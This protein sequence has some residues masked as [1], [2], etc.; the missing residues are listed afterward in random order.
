MD[1]NGK[2]VTVRKAAY[3][4]LTLPTQPRKNDWYPVNLPFDAYLADVRNAED[5]LPPLLYLKDYAIAVYDGQR[6]ATYGIGN[7]PSN[8]DNDWQYF[9]GAMMDNG[10]AYMAAADGIGTLRFKAANLADLFTAT[11]APLLYYTGPAGATH[12]GINYVAQPTGING[13]AGGAIPPGSIVQ[14]SENLSSDR[15]SA[16]SYVAKTVSPSLVIAPYTN[17]FYQTDANG[18]VSY[19]K[20]TAAATVRSGNAA[21]AA[22]VPP[23]YYEL[24]LYEGGDPSHY[25]ALFAAASEFASPDTYETGRD[26]VKMGGLQGNALRI[27]SHAFDVDLCASE[28]VMEHNHAHIPMHIHLPVAG[29]R[30]ALRLENTLNDRE[31]L[32]LCRNSQLIHNLTKHPEYILESAGGTTD[33][34]SLSILSGITGTEVITSPDVFAYTEN[35]KIV[36]SG[37]RPNEE[38]AIYDLSGRLHAKGK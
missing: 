38:Y 35:G 4:D 29:K 6:R 13:T 37:L 36:I 1:R 5:T 8:P 34:Y 33:E 20:A 11:T 27:W 2:A 10:A 7:Q 3:L 26:V 14:V 18:T 32:W 24:R 19:T 30:Y 22:A 23:Y 15:T 31:Q 25:D 16:T 21:T 17:Y 12:Q 9:Q 28:V